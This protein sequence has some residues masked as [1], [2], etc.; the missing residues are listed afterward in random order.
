MGKQKVKEYETVEKEVEVQVC[1]E[2]GE[3]MGPV[4]KVTPHRVALDPEVSYSIDKGRFN[5]DISQLED[6]LSD[7]WRSTKP[8]TQSIERV[9]RAEVRHICKRI[10]Q[11]T[12]DPTIDV[13]FEVEGVKE[14]CPRCAAEHGI[15]GEPSEAEFTVVDRSPTGGNLSDTREGVGYVAL[16]CS[17]LAVLSLIG[18]LVFSVG[19]LMPVMVLLSGMAIGMLYFESKLEDAES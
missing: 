19:F 15:E 11:T 12:Y 2:C 18:W 6:A 9:S 14:I 1:D 5:R 13:E 16:L 7:L 8:G 3:Q 17:F 4:D 10:Q